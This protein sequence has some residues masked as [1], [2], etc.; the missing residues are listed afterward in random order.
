[1]YVTQSEGSRL[2]GSTPEKQTAALNTVA[3]L[4]PGTLILEV[5]CEHIH[6]KE[7]IFRMLQGEEDELSE[8][9]C[10]VEGMTVDR[11]PTLNAPTFRN[12]TP[13]TLTVTLIDESCYTAKFVPD[14]QRHTA[15]RSVRAI[16]REEEHANDLS[17]V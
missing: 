10:E 14:N 5:A 11:H 4:A 12:A 16:S 6:D 3:M 9:S 17:R 1:M 7:R 8:E 13:G 15:R 2:L